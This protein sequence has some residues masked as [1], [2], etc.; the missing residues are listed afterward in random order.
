MK[1][2]T[3]NRAN[4]RFLFSLYVIKQP[5]L[6]SNISLTM[7]CGLLKKKFSNKVAW[8][9]VTESQIIKSS[10]SNI[11]KSAFYIFIQRQLVT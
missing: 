11:L 2:E 3:R 8:F 1:N 9:G 5:D 6:F 7:E 10:I 4:V